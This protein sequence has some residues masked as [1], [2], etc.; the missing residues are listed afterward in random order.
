[1]AEIVDPLALMGSPVVEAAKPV[2]PVDHRPVP[3]SELSPEER[4]IRELEDQL[5]KLRGSRAEAAEPELVAPS[6]QAEKKIL[7]HFLED[8]FT[9]CGNVWV[10]GQELEFDIPGR[11]YESTKD[12]F[13]NSW[14]SYA[15][16]DFAQ[17]ERYGKIFFRLGPW[18]GRKISEGA[19]L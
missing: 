14:L 12:R 8:G 10:R 9:A 17:V 11:A 6:P 16:D 13:G 4:H 5:V 1:M 18:P 15:G 7:I 3:A 2:P 19:G